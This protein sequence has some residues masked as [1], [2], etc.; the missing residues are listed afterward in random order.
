MTQ[1]DL[2]AFDEAARLAVADFANLDASTLTRMEYSENATYQV[3]DYAGQ[4]FVLRINRPF[5]HSKAQIAAEIH[6][7]HDLHMALPF[8][9]SKPIA[10][11]NGDYIGTQHVEGTRYHSTLFTF[12]AGQAPAEG[13]VNVFE[14]LG[15]I[16]AQFHTHSVQ[17]HARYQHY[18]RMTWDE[19]TILGE[20]AKWGR[21]QDGRGM[22][23]ARIAQY[24]QAVA[25]MRERL[26]AYGKHPSRFGLIHADLRSANLLV[27]Q[28]EL[29]IIDFD[30]C[31]FSW[32]L[33]DF[34]A[35][36]SFVEH[37]PYVADLQAAWLKGYR[38]YRALTEEDE[39]MLATFVLLR[40]LQLIA[41]IGSRTN[42]TTERL[43]AAYTYASDAL[44]ARYL[45]P[46][47]G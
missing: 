6:W 31:G 40:R 5:Y 42:A 34:A 28:G 21:W 23:A 38:R 45:A 9:V 43:G 39:A 47:N 19:L 32:L 8:A 7:L 14:Q 33:Y 11:A 46:P 37:E 2:R 44:V 4:A 20:D 15:E 22:T 26:A 24:E 18:D 13:D 16:T 36:I 30:D 25:L 10:M 3:K 12:V 1:K 27:A 17:Q 29:K 35:A 41:W